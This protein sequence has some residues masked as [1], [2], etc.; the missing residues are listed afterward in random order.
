VDLFHADAACYETGMGHAAHAN[1]NERLDN[2]VVFGQHERRPTVSSKNL[3]LPIAMLT[4]LNCVTAYAG[5]SAHY[6]CSGRAEVG[7]TDKGNKVRQISMKFS[8]SRYHGG[9]RRYDLSSAYGGKLFVGSTIDS[10]HDGW[11]KGTVVL[12]SGKDDFYRGDFKMEE[13]E[14]G[15]GLA[16]TGDIIFDGAVY[17]VKAILPCKELR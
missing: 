7:S 6:I 14:A 12:Q 10:S 16:I 15:Y 1:V 4:A 11:G 9:S 13:R 5:D 8:D 2:L 17:N 3:I